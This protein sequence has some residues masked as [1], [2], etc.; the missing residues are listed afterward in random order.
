MGVTI[1][2]PGHDVVE[3]GGKPSYV[4]YH[5]SISEDGSTWSA[6]RRW[7]DL[8]QTAQALLKAYP[9]L[10]KLEGSQLNGLKSSR[11]FDFEFREGRA[12]AMRA[13]LQAVSD[14]VGLSFRE[15]TGPEMLR[16]LLAKDA[17]PGEHT[18]LLHVLQQ[19]V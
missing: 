18:N 10:P 4:S 11:T 14:D 19:P 16:L 12:R 17:Q 3:Q 13:W 9:K 6:H 2:V 7:N 15:Q 1:D 8:K 5:I